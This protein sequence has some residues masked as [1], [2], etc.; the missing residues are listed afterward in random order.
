MRK[1]KQYVVQRNDKNTKTKQKT[2]YLIIT[3]TK[4]IKSPNKT[5]THR[6]RK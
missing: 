2:L 5:N 4:Q 6:K 1:T 3:A